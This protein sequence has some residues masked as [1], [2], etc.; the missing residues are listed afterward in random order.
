MWAL[1]VV[2]EYS[3]VDDDGDETDP[4]VKASPQHPSEI[5]T[6]LFGFCFFQKKNLGTNRFFF[7][8][9]FLTS[10]MFLLWQ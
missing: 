4:L 9:L 6:N 5:Q 7:L 10:R 2:V 1:V 8:V 3:A